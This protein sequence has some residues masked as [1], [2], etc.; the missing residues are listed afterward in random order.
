MGP[1]LPPATGIA[2][3]RYLSSFR[4]PTSSRRSDVVLEAEYEELG[5]PQASAAVDAPYT[6]SEVNVEITACAP[7]AAMSEKLCWANEYEEDA[8]DADADA[9][10]E[11]AVAAMSS[12][13]LPTPTSAIAAASA[14]S[15]RSDVPTDV[16]GQIG[17]P[18]DGSHATLALWFAVS[19]N[20]YKMAQNVLNHGEF[21]EPDL[22]DPHGWSLLHLAAYRGNA[23]LMMLVLQ[24][25]VE[26]DGKSS[27]GHTP[28]HVAVARG[29]AD[30]VDLLLEY[31][32]DASYA[33]P[34]GNTPF[35][36]WWFDSV[37][38]D[39]RI[40]LLLIKHG[41]DLSVMHSSGASPLTVGVAKPDPA[42]ED[43]MLAVL[44]TDTGRAHA[45]TLFRQSASSS[46]SDGGSAVAVTAVH[47]V[48]LAASLDY[49]R[50]L[51]RLLD[52][53]A[54]AHARYDGR[55]LLEY[56]VA[57][58]AA[59]ALKVLLARGVRPDAALTPAA[60][61]AAATGA[62]AAASA[63]SSGRTTSADPF[64]SLVPSSPLALAARLGHARIAAE[65]V[66][67]GADPDGSE[68]ERLR[69]TDLSPAVDADPAAVVTP[70]V[71]AAAKP[72]A[73]GAAVVA[74]MLRAARGPAPAAGAPESLGNALRFA[75]QLGGHAAV[76]TLIGEAGEEALLRSARS[77]LAGAMAGAADYVGDRAASQ[78]A[79]FRAHGALPPLASLHKLVAQNPHVLR[80]FADRFGAYSIAAD[81]GTLGNGV[82]LRY[83]R[84]AGANFRL[85]DARGT[86]LHAAIRA[87]NTAA[88]VTTLVGECGVPATALDLTGASAMDVARAVRN[89]GAVTMLTLLVTGG[90]PTNPVVSRRALKPY[91]PRAYTTQEIEAELAR[92][93]AG[94]A[95][96]PDAKPDRLACVAAYCAVT[97]TAPEDAPFA[98]PEV[99]ERARARAEAARAEDERRSNKLLAVSDLLRHQKQ[100]A[101]AAGIRDGGG[102][103]ASLFEKMKT[104]NARLGTSS[105]GA[106]AA[107][108]R[109]RRR[110]PK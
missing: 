93:R 17:Y 57:G 105:S 110:A 47:P 66:A 3:R 103:S 94:V 42:L 29:N 28:L 78:D 16:Y 109:T 99:L 31:G 72:G 32:A 88:D 108:G 39:P 26:P 91:Q 77:M 6:A 8:A 50:A 37:S 61:A 55:S 81:A 56:A 25:G 48:S 7:H 62:P 22:T 14:L 102:R 9:D 96:A 100:P 104:A 83:L 79:A 106:A 1:F 49:A 95:P 23:R 68:R 92:A 5:A 41:A 58:D 71:L 36:A 27:R 52:A 33:A 101:E 73:V 65:L 38:T 44:D 84:L 18:K 43:V 21:V 40:P 80:G 13:R 74:G 63:A 45:N 30:A 107:G 86:A 51:T 4:T 75:A 64:A 24:L 89:D 11:E 59:A 12:R 34:G 76:D 53:G 15:G 87:R 54:D 35:Y 69:V 46:S 20:D 10:A 70:L 60:L 2:E 19:Q 90:A 85:S 97:G 98:P 82:V 67:A